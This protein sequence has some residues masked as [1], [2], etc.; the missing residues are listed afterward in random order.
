[1]LNALQT[2]LPNSTDEEIRTAAQ[3]QI[4]ITLLRIDKAL[5]AKDEN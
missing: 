2:R 3:E 4:K 5:T 1:M